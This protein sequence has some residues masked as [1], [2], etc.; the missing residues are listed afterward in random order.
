MAASDTAAWS[1]GDE[2]QFL[3]IDRLCWLRVDQGGRSR[4]QN[5]TLGSLGLSV[6]M[7]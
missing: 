6:T 2:G 3:D 1:T 7:S 5:T 4:L